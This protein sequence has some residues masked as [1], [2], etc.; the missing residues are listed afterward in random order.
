[1]KNTLDP[2][3]S[4]LPQLKDMHN[5]SQLKPQ[6]S[7]TSQKAAQPDHSEQHGNTIHKHQRMQPPHS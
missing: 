2:T 4:A 5:Q 1:M 7:P 3:P 6:T